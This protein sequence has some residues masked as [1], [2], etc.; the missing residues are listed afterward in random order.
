[1]SKEKE[2]DCL[3]QPNSVLSKSIQQFLLKLYNMVSDEATERYIRW[4]PLGTSFIVSNS[5][6]LAEKVLPKFFKHSKFT[7]FVRQLNMYGFY[8][9]PHITQ[10]EVLDNDNW[11]FANEFFI[12]GQP[13]LMCLI[14]RKKTGHADDE[15]P[16][17]Q[18]NQSV[19]LLLGD[20]SALRKH[21][22]VLSAEQ[23]DL[24]TNMHLFYKEVLNVQTILQRQQTEI[25]K[26][27]RFLTSLYL[28]SAKG[29]PD[30]NKPTKRRMLE[31]KVPD[32]KELFE[33]INSSAL[34]S[35]LFDNNRMCEFMVQSS[36]DQC[37]DLNEK[38]KRMHNEISLLEDNMFELERSADPYLHFDD[39][40]SDFDSI[41]P[42]IEGPLDDDD[43]PLML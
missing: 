29:V 25:D 12:R 10:N 32:Q 43:I 41:L 24:Q 26:I 28:M 2:K 6:D 36:L 37:A 15:E 34:N 8:K 35:N 40:K 18:Q 19:S 13:D 9:V 7:S 11:E 14:T 16:K 38:S 39:P 22:L 1:M 33:M 4:S 31:A 21:Q 20:L 5:K 17:N 30:E 27:M 42:L 23:R 3:V